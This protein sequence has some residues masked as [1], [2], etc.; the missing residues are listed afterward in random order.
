MLDLVYVLGALLL[1]A[2]VAVVGWAVE[3]L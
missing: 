1:I 3:R 2:L